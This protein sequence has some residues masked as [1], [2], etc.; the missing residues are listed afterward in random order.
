[1]QITRSAL[2]SIVGVV[3]HV[4]PYIGA[5]CEKGKLVVYIFVGTRRAG[6][7]DLLPSTKAN[8]S[9]LKL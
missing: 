3:A 5:F 2:R 4:E 1:M 6:F 9:A 8:L 7:D